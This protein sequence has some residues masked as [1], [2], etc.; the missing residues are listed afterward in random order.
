ML[1]DCLPTLTAA[2]HLPTHMAPLVSNE[3]HKIP[4]SLLT[5]FPTFT[6]YV[7]RVFSFEKVLF[8]FVE[9]FLQRVKSDPSESMWTT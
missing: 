8:A 4:L 7:F 9:P 5:T 2:A 3:K 1:E 6:K